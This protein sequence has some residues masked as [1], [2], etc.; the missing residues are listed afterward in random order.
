MKELTLGTNTIDVGNV[1]R[2][3]YIPVFLKNMKEFILERNPVDVS[4]VGKL[5]TSTQL[6]NHK[7]NSH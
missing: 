3:S 2:H 5:V 6:K 7:R 4:N 1:E